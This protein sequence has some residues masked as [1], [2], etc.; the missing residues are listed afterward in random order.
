[1][2]TF[3][4]EILTFHPFFCSSASILAASFLYSTKMMTLFLRL[5]W[6]LRSSSSRRESL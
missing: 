3:T 1:M 5:L 2:E 6:Y 4:H